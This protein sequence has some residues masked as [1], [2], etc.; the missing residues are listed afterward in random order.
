MSASSHFIA[1]RRRGIAGAILGGWLI[2]SALLALGQ[3]R[4]T[5]ENPQGKWEVFEGCTL[6][7]N[8][9]S[10]GDSFQ[11]LHKGRTYIFRLYFVDAPE[12]DASLRERI[13]D[14]AAYFGVAKAEIPRGGRLAAQFTHEKLKGREFTVVTRWQN[15]LGRSTLA[16]FYCMVLVKGENLAEALVASGL[17]RI[18]GLRANW[19]DGLRSTT[20]VNKL[21]NL[22]LTAR[23]QHRGLWDEKSFPRTATTGAMRA[24][25]LVGGRIEAGTVDVNEASAAELQT[26]PG[27]G[28]KLAER[29]MANRPYLKVDDLLRVSG[30]GSMTIEQFRERVRVESPEE[31]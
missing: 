13:T 28:P 29:I 5:D 24:S 30:I 3:Q 17:A 9:F 31:K 1:S 26:L 8:S 6:S 27:I 14:Q 21:K 20:F 18:Y 22:E 7:T 16:R 11:V 15:A 4:R 2:F 12:A 25:T 23:E 19:P 10:D